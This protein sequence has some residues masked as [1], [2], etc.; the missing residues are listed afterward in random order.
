M[1]ANLCFR[2]RTGSVPVVV[3]DGMSCLRPLY[4]KFSWLNGGQYKEFYDLLQY[5][6]SSFTNLGCELFVFFDGPPPKIK[7][8]MWKKRRLSSAEEVSNVFDTLDNGVVS[9]ENNCRTSFL[10][11]GLGS[12]FLYLMGIN[13]QCKVSALYEIFLVMNI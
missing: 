5:F 2:Y 4:R 1:F 13:K 3:I 7:L 12:I 6:I 11:N 9:A 8:P 10:P